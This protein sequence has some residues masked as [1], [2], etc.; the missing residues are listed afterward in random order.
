M[1]SPYLEKR[2]A[3]LNEEIR[4]YPGPIARCDEHLPALLEERA[5]LVAKLQA[6]QDRE[7]CPPPARWGHDGGRIDE[8][9]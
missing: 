5:R 2:L 6:L 1:R 3:E 8:K 4:H 9:E 7:S